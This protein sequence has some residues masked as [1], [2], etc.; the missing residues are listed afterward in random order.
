MR[1]R[2]A[3]IDTISQAFEGAR[4]MGS[5]IRAYPWRPL[6][7]RHRIVS[8]AGNARL[9][10]VIHHDLSQA[11]LKQKWIGLMDVLN[12]LASPN[13]RLTANAPF[14]TPYSHPIH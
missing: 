11:K 10:P 8:D 1:R 7:L 2:T 12:N 14:S 5:R 3:Q 13:D 4:Q 9:R 6:V